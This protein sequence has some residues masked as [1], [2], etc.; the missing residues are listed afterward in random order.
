MSDR[1]DVSELEFHLRELHVDMR[2]LAR[3]LNAGRRA[4]LTIR[5]LHVIEQ[6]LSHDLVHHLGR[7]FELLGAQEEAA[8]CRS[9]A[10][11]LDADE[12][13]GRDGLPVD[14]LDGADLVG[15]AAAGEQAWAEG[16]VTAELVGALARLLDALCA[17][18]PTGGR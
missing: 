7:A 17:P 12:G 18:L 14:M 16:V 10:E 1:V 3:W 8:R 5:Q 9:A 15:A 2:Q 11:V 13:P 4:P 6:Q